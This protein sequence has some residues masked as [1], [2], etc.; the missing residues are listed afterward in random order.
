M[1]SAYYGDHAKP[2]GLN[3][4]YLDAYYERHWAEKAAIGDFGASGEL[5]FGLMFLEAAEES[6]NPDRI[7]RAKQV[8]QR[9]GMLAAKEARF[10]GVEIN[11]WE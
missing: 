5:E 9:A 10:R 8:I 2:G 4:S 11:G 6:G 3:D 1:G 7:D